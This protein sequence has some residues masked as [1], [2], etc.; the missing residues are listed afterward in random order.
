VCVV[1]AAVC[2]VR[3]GGDWTERSAGAL[4]CAMPQRG[5]QCEGTRDGTMLRTRA[6]GAVTLDFSARSLALARRLSMSA[7]LLGHKRRTSAVFA[8]P[9]HPSRLSCARRATHP[10]GRSP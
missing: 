6:T 1:D 3:A 9:P 4:V 10:C 7:A 2:L 5:V 8:A